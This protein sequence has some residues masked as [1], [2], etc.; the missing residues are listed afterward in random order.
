[1]SERLKCKP[2]FMLTFS[3]LLD[4]HNG[5]C[6][7]ENL[8]QNIAQNSPTTVYMVGESLWNNWLLRLETDDNFVYPVIEYRSQGRGHEPDNRVWLYLNVMNI[9]EKSEMMMNRVNRTFKGPGVSI[10][11]VPNDLSIEYGIQLITR[12]FRIEPWRPNLHDI[13][14]DSRRQQLEI[15]SCLRSFYV[16]RELLSFHSPYFHSL[17]PDKKK[18]D[19]DWPKFD[20]CTGGFNLCLRI[21]LGE[22]VKLSL[23]PEADVR[24]CSDSAKR[25]LVVADDLQLAN[26]IRHCER[27]MIEGSERFDMKKALLIA[28]T[29][30]L[31]HFYHHLIRKVKDVK[32][33]HDVIDEENLNEMPGELAKA[34]VKMFFDGSL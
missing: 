29:H 10:Q 9:E 19:V 20:F 16:S 23:P 26:V 7:F 18:V 13:C 6:H 25:V 5:I 11:D 21:A 14:F 33:L 17:P 1:M 24:L 34:T 15:Y 32:S 12:R 31:R 27:Q 30:N 2:F 4:G 22:Y 28:C 3:E 8:Q